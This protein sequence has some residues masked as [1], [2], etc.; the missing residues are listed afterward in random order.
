MESGSVT[1][2][3]VAHF[4]RKSLLDHVRELVARWRVF[5]L[6][7]LAV[8]GVL[9]TGLEA[10]AYFLRADLRGARFYVGAIVASLLCAGFWIIR[11]YLRD[12][13]PG[14]E[15]E[16]ARARRIAQVQRSRWEYGLAKQLLQDVLLELDDEL[17]ALSEGHVFVL[18]ERKPDL[19]EYVEWV[20]LGPTN[21]LRMIDVAQRLLILDLPT[22]LGS[23]DEL[24]K[25][26]AIRSVVYRIRDLYKESVVFERSRRAVE[27]P[28][29][30]ERLHE[31]QLGWTNPV[32]DGVRQM[33]EY[34]DR[35]LGL[36]SLRDQEVAFTVAMEE[37]SNL[38]DFNAELERIQRADA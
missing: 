32:R 10:P 33:F 17:A 5:S 21:L 36:E 29:G 20:S 22:V 7:A 8:F 9:W 15:Q 34:F 23:E 27:P 2:E 18:I 31:L 38:K 35:I 13:P 12:C 16:S 3:L 11:T 1:N 25:P 24:A 19:P 14:L 37:P 4:T 26:R 6:T 28:E 30:A